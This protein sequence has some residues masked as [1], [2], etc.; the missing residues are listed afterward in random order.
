MILP[1][2]L[3]VCLFYCLSARLLKVV[4]GFFNEIFGRVSVASSNNHLGF[5]GYLD[6]DADPGFL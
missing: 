6:H 1:L 2:C 3:C 5:G 4:N